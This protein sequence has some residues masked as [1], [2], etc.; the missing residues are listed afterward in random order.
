[1]PFVGKHGTTLTAFA[2]SATRQQRRCSLDGRKAEILKERTTGTQH[3]TVSCA[4]YECICNLK[5][6]VSSCIIL[7]IL[8]GLTR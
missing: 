1:M 7:G 8:M 4:S 6:P 3:I 5:E 2:I